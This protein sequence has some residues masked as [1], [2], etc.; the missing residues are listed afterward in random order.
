M[1]IKLITLSVA[2]LLATNVYAEPV[3]DQ[4]AKAEDV[5]IVKTQEVVKAVPA[6]VTVEAPTQEVT[7]MVKPMSEH[8]SAKEFELKV[9]A[10][11]KFDNYGGIEVIRN[12]SDIGLGELYEIKLGGKDNGIMSG[13]MTY[14]FLGDIIK[15]DKGTHSNISDSYRSSLM[16]KVAA[17]E[18]ST[19][20]E[21]V[22]I[23]YSPTVE[24]IGTMFVYT[25]TSCGYCRKLHSEIDELTS[26]GVEVKY[27][28]YPRSSADLQVP[29]SRDAKGELVY[30]ENQTLKEMASIYCQEDKESA[31]T[32]VKGGGNTDSYQEDYLANKAS[33]DEIIKL[34][35]ESGKKIGFG[36]T[37]FLYL[38][39][40]TA[41]PGYQPAAAI[42]KMFKSKK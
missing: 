16:E 26:N 27:I 2:T 9:A 11:G 4:V 32:A 10:S 19:L 6:E 22:F 24:K 17:E 1:K 33:C 20:P 37:P 3:T 21:E 25:D 40:G 12:V 28:P 5:A 42:V 38:D 7:D 29:I 31:L 41:I 13:D 30:G 36:G 14:V 39:N 15:F 23:T 34:G 18:A 35:Y 8:L